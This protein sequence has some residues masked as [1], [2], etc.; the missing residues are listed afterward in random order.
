[1]TEEEQLWDN[2]DR[3]EDFGKDPE[4]LLCQHLVGF[5]RVCEHLTFIKV[6][7]PRT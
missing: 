4:N 3:F 5:L 6:L 2:A 1:L 7:C